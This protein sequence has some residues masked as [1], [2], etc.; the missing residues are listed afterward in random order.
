MSVARSTL[1]RVLRERTGRAPRQAWTQA[2]SWLRVNWGGSSSN[3][4]GR[5]WMVARNR[6]MPVPRKNRFSGITG[7]GPHPFSTPRRVK[8]QARLFPSDKHRPQP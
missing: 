8:I 6:A 2:C 5:Y 4:T 1:K 3:T 7:I